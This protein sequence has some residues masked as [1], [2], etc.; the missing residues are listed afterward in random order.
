M[1]SMRKPKE[2][3]RRMEHEDRVVQSADTYT[4]TLFR[5]ETGWYSMDFKTKEMAI[6]VATEFVNDP[7]FNKGGRPASIYAVATGLHGHFVLIGT[8]FKG[9]LYRPAVR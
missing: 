3:N 4:F 1:P 5:G 7:E 9:G 8:V 2:P 6:A